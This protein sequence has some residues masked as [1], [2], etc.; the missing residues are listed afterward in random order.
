MMIGGFTIV[1]SRALLFDPCF[2]LCL[3]LAWIENSVIRVVREKRANVE[4]TLKRNGFSL[5]FQGYFAAERRK[6]G[7]SHTKKGKQKEGS[8]TTHS[9]KPSASRASGQSLFFALSPLPLPTSDRKRPPA[10]A[11]QDK[12]R[13]IIKTTGDRCCC[14]WAVAGVA[15][16]DAGERLV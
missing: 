12:N 15:A 11:R 7:R 10:I 16:G 6:E 9:K 4:Y 2:Y 5:L 8:T 13:T 1:F 3:V 14:W